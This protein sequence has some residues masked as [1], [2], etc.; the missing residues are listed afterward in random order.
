MR[1]PFFVL[2]RPWAADFVGE[3]RLREQTK[4]GV[5]NC[6]SR[7]TGKPHQH[8]GSLH[9]PDRTGVLRN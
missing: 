1:G 7:T 3:E 8:Y 4:N 5:Y 6:D 2:G 9:R